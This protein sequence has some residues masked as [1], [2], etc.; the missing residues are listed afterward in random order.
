MLFG[1]LPARAQ[2]WEP[3]AAVLWVFAGPC[4][5]LGVLVMVGWW[6]NQNMWNKSNNYESVRRKDSLQS[7]LVCEVEKMRDALRWFELLTWCSKGQHMEFLFEHFRLIWILDQPDHCTT[8][9][10]IRWTPRTSCRIRQLWWRTGNHSYFC[11]NN[12]PPEWWI[13]SSPLP[14]W[15]AAQPAVVTILVFTTFAWGFLGTS[16]TTNTL[17]TNKQLAKMLFSLQLSGGLMGFLSFTIFTEIPWVL[18]HSCFES[19]QSCKGLTFGISMV[20]SWDDLD[21]SYQ[22]QMKV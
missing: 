15:Y 14:V 6:K 12:Y 7:E 20:V 1:G 4:F 8:R 19:Y 3:Q 2:Y 22:R 16:S 17:M 10:Q 21:P 5:D 9:Y 11:I 18:W 13:G